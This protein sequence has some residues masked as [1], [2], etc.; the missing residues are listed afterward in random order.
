[1]IDETYIFERSRLSWIDKKFFFE[2]FS[3]L[4][5]YSLSSEDTLLELLEEDFL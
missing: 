2:E 1:M 5:Y 3:S 4:F